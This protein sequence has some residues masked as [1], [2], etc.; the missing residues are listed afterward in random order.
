M[1]SLFEE[2]LGPFIDA[3][4]KYWKL[5]E[6]FFVIRPLSPGYRIK[7]HRLVENHREMNT[8]VC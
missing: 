6:G 5:A 7:L 1:Q 2:S 8:R 3:S 4:E